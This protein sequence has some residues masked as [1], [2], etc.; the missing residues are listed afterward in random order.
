[1]TIASK[2]SPGVSSSVVTFVLALAALVAPTRDLRAQDIL[3]EKSDKPVAEG[4][5]DR[6]A[7]PG[8]RSGKRHGRY[9][10]PAPEDLGPELKVHTIVKGD[11]LWDLAQ[12]YL[13]D[14]YL[15]PQ[16]WEVNRYILDPHWIYPGDPLVIPQ[17]LLIAE[18]V[19]PDLA[20]LPAPQPVAKRFD[21]YCAPYILPLPP[22]EKPKKRRPTKA[23]GA[24]GEEQ[25]ATA[26][27][28][29]TFAAAEAEA[30]GWTELAAAVPEATLAMA[31]ADKGAGA[32]DEKE[33]KRADKAAEKARARA[34]H[35]AEKARKKAERAERGARKHADRE[36]AK[37][38]RAA[39]RK[40]AEELAILGKEP[41]ILGGEDVALNFAD[42]QVVYINRGEVNG[43]KAGDEFLVSR[44]DG[45]VY[46]PQTELP[47]GIAM[48]MVGILR[49][50]CTQQK[51][52]TAVIMSSCEALTVGDHLRPLEPIP[53]PLASE[54]EP[55][56]RQCGTPS[57]RP[58]GHLVYS[59]YRKIALG[60]QDLANISIGS[61]AG[62][63]PGDFFVV[64]HNNERGPLFPSV[65]VG[66]AV[67][68][69]VERDTAT[70][71]L[72]AS[73]SEVYVGDQVQLR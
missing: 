5:A 52:S 36:A 11:T 64:F 12:T 20:V 32:G 4:K 23:E 41:A 37:A 70:V 25:R 27:Y 48:Q 43:V 61:S 3:L 72:M 63:V 59:K 9:S 22:D 69:L 24:S 19:A 1:M 46:H 6:K 16:I 58:A 21:V 44:P 38:R 10:P 33:R 51:V 73:S 65:V 66:D 56:P 7:K 68:L 54:F 40:E 18:P 30:R 2:V 60:E 35:D 17:P 67:V 42:G 71:K 39:E 55:T 47:I 45:I 50:L 8:K 53:I 62:I 34:S 31:G 14:P 13:G 57:E 28:E 49:V 29:A 15:W 26:G